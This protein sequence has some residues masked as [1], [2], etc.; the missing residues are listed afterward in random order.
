MNATPRRRILVV[1]DDRTFR[2]STAEL[3]RQDG[4]DIDVAGDASEAVEWLR[5]GAF[6]LVLLDMRMPGMDGLTAVEVLR[7]RVSI[8]VK[9]GNIAPV[10]FIDHSVCPER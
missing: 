8:L 9:M 6:D 2:L 3:L 1:D 5:T 10:L 7:T 4:H